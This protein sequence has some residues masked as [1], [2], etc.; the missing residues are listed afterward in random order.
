MNISGHEPKKVLNSVSILL[1]IELLV[2]ILVSDL[3]QG[4]NSMSLLFFFFRKKKKW[5]LMQDEALKFIFCGVPSNFES[6]DQQSKL[7]E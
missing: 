7:N 3:E 5:Q 1:I 6:E 4:I 2:I